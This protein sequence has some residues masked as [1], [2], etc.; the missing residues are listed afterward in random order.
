MAAVHINKSSVLQVRFALVWVVYAQ[1][2]FLG[3]PCE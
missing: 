3:N 2:L 1:V